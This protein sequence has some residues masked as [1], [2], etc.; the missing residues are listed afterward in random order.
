[1]QVLY[2]TARVEIPS[3]ISRQDMQE[4]VSSVKYRNLPN[5]T[6]KIYSKSKSPK[7]MPHDLDIT[8]SYSR[9]G[10]AWWAGAIY[11]YCNLLVPGTTCATLYH[12]HARTEPDEDPKMVALTSS[13]S[14]YRVPGTR[15]GSGF[16]LPLLYPRRKIAKSQKETI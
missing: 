3:S 1:M 2:C 7:S 15:S 14:W 5:H 11:S 4:R 6:I 12:W 16:P 8:T 9:P 10:L 13:I